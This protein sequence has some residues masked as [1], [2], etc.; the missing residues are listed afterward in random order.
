MIKRLSS[1]RLCYPEGMTITV[2]LPDDITQHA[3]P[4]REALEALALEG[5]RSGT[6]TQ[7]QVG[8]LLGISRFETEL[9]LARHLDLYDYSMEELEAEASLLRGLRG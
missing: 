4:G 3:D 9:F 1:L 6:L 8:Q 5:Y 7:F 2:G